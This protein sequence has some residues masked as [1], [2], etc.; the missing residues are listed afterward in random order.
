MLNKNSQIHNKPKKSTVREWVEAILIAFLLALFI[1]SIFIQAYKIPSGSMEE[2]LLIG[3]HLLV[4]KMAYGLHVPNEIIFFGWQ[5][6]PD[7]I[8]F[9]TTPEREDI[10]VF[11]YPEDESRDFI[12]RVIGLPGDKLEIR[13]QKVYINDKPIQ[14]AYTHHTQPPSIE[15]IE[16][17]D[18]FGPVRVPEGYVFVM[19]DNRENSHDSR[20][21]GYLDVNKIRGK[22]KWIYFS[23]DSEDSGV[24]WSRIFQ[25]VYN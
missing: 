14:E 1:R 24:R 25:S 10:V 16:K 17:R 4:N 8:F 22:A 6:F 5:I 12:K 15:R 3:D 18:D 9:Q 21:W 20:F 19:G 23:W 11:K 2:T 13:H 7:I